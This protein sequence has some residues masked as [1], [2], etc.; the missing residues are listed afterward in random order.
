MKAINAPYSPEYFESG[1]EI[2]DGISD[3]GVFRGM[4]TVFDDKPDTSCMSDIIMPGA[5]QKTLRQ[6]GRN[7]NGVVMLSQHG[8]FDLN[9]IGIWSHL[10][11][12]EKGLE[13]VGELAVDGSARI[14]SGKGTTLANET[15]SL[16]QMKAL[17]GLSI[18]FDFPRNKSGR[19][20]EGVIEFDKEKENRIIKEIILWEVSPVTF[21]AKLNA[22][23]TNVKSITEATTERELEHALKDTG[24]TRNDA[25]YMVK[26]SRDKLREARR[27]GDSSGMSVILGA[28]KEVNQNSKGYNKWH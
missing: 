7:R 4:G 3:Q 2:K 9:P 21:P 12:T 18:G 10:A 1:L 22:N 24:M 8:R 26:L 6:G 15:H 19:I 28:L 11:E 25:L 5:F 14:K 23:I 20:K 27:M 17:R 13:L 16:M